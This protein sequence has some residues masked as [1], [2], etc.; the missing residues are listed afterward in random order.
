MSDSLRL[1]IRSPDR[2]KLQMGSGTQQSFVFRNPSGTS[3]YNKLYNK[4]AINGVELVG[5]IALSNL[6][7]GIILDGGDAAYVCGGGE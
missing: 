7:S 3:D 1:Q 4:P 2:V 5:A 6:L